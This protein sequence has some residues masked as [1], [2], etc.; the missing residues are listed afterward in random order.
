MITIDVESTLSEWNDVSTH[1]SWIWILASWPSDTER[2]RFH[3]LYSIQYMSSTG[4]FSAYPQMIFF[5]VVCYFCLFFPPMMQAIIS[6]KQQKTQQVVTI[7]RVFF[8][9][10]S[11]QIILVC[12]LDQSPQ[13]T[14]LL[15]SWLVLQGN[16]FQVGPVGWV[17]GED[18]YVD[19][20]VSKNR[21]TP[22]NGWF[23][24]E[25][26]IQ[27]DDLRVPLFSETLICYDDGP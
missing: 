4:I 2:P 12:E 20:G 14:S 1:V 15:R 17:E 3:W 9:L 11:R 22:Q 5:S 10:K 16:S 23:M 8:P 27:M 25:N 13:P 26:P 18:G 7:H 24:M 6:P 21:D 19:M